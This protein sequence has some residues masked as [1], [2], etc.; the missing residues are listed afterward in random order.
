M[1]KREREAAVRHVLTRAQRREF[2]KIL[3]LGDNQGYAK[4][5]VKF[6]AINGAAL[7]NTLRLAAARRAK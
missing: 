6:C 3:N 4:E 5:V 1:T 7:C 2:I